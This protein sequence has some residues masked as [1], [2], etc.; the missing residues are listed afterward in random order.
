MATRA[1]AKSRSLWDP[2]LVKRAI[3]DSFRMMVV[4]ALRVA[5]GLSA[6][7]GGYAWRGEVGFVIGVAAVELLLYPFQAVMLRAKGF[8]QP[9]VDLPLFAFAAAAIALGAWRA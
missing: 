1:T 4:N 9:G 3:G 7:L 5:I 6:M 2:V 8:W